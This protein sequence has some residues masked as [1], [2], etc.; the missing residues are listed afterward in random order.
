MIVAITFVRDRWISKHNRELSVFGLDMPVHSF[1]LLYIHK[2]PSVANLCT[3]DLTRSLLLSR[4][5]CLLLRQRSVQ[6]CE[7]MVYNAGTFYHINQLFSS[8]SSTELTSRRD[9]ETVGHTRLRSGSKLIV[10]IESSVFRSY[11]RKVCF[12]VE[13]LVIGV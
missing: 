3:I 12:Q 5:S 1:I 4:D 2:R 8:P 10:C 7:K 9:P 6:G 13:V 11:L